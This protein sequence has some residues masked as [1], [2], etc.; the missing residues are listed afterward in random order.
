[1]TDASYESDRVAASFNKT[2]AT[3]DAARRKL[4]P[5]F[6]KFYGWA[7][8]LLPFET[9][10]PIRVLDLGAGT[11]LLSAWVLAAFPHARLR[12]VDI[13]E[14]ML[15]RARERFA[16]TTPAPRIE[17]LDFVHEDLGGPYDGVVSA[18]SIHHLSDELK[19]DVFRRVYEA[20]SP[21]GIFVNAEQVLGPTPEVE[22]EYKKIWLDDARAL[23]A[24][25]EEVE[26]ALV[27]MREDRCAP[28]EIQV[29]WLR[30]LGFE[31]ADCWFKEARFAV[32]SGRKRR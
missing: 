5:C 31:D 25:G 24:T 30:E 26:A 10:D 2:A 16:G 8:R 27:R 23:G 20:L 13:S 32:Y 15:D 28:V 9:E 29:A 1:M 12:L 22:A 14:P 19:R 11:G 7:V 18:L 6:D 17:T 3:Y 21:G 4:V